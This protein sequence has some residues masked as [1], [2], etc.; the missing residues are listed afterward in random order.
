MSI[1]FNKYHWFAFYA[2][3]QIMPAE[4]RARSMWNT[5]IAVW[6]EENGSIHAWKNRC[7]HRGMRLSYGFIRGSQLVCLYHGWNY[8]GAT[9]QCSYIPAQPNLKGP[10][11]ACVRDFA[12]FE[13]H[14]LVWI[15]TVAEAE[16]EPDFSDFGEAEQ[17]IHFCRSIFVNESP[18]LVGEILKTSIF[19]PYGNDLADGAKLKIETSQ[20]EHHQ[21]GANY[22]A[23]WQSGRDKKKKTEL[24]CQTE[25]RNNAILVNH[26][27]DDQGNEGSLIF[28]LLPIDDKKTGV[29]VLFSGDF[30]SQSLTSAKRHYAKWAKRMRWSIEN[31]NLQTDSFNP[32][33]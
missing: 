23:I 8:E 2:S 9:A 30:S 4:I 33:I 20:A 11:T 29:H 31:R 26:Y 27:K 6:R 24:T 18:G 13:K 19:I 21:T 15:S 7:P 3:Q 17:T 10:K 28:A 5:D 22:Q 14:G 32:W 12:C 1:N 25:V 16:K